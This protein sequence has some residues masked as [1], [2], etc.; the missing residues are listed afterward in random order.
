MALRLDLSKTHH[1]MKW[2]KD[3]LYF[4]VKRG[5]GKWDRGAGWCDSVRRGGVRCDSVRVG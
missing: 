4:G 3:V 5:R 1:Q 2:A